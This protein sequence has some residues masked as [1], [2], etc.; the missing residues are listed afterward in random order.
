ML[1]DNGRRDYCRHRHRRAGGGSS[2][3]QLERRE[4]R[5]R[6][7]ALDLTD[8]RM[9]STVTMPSHGRGASCARYR[10]ASRGKEFAHRAHGLTVGLLG[11]ARHR[12]QLQTQVGRET[13]N[14]L[15]RRS[16]GARGRDRIAHQESRWL[17]RGRH[18][19]LGRQLRSILARHGWLPPSDATP[20]QVLAPAE[21]RG[22]AQAMGP[23][24]DAGPSLAFPGQGGR[25]GQRRLRGISVPEG[26]VGG[27]EH[28]VRPRLV[29]QCSHV[30]EDV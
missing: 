27:A 17:A 16:Q 22:L 23:D 7:H 20:L 28:G 29:Q 11:R 25:L 8:I 1:R 2:C 5:P 30:M 13:L 15:G 21:L 24:Q 14:R 19:Q 9:G 12:M 4:F 10:G 18:A 3:S 6:N 26:S